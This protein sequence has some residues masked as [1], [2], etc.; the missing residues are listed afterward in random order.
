MISPFFF[1]VEL[2]SFYVHFGWGWVER[3][4]TQRKPSKTA[5]WVEKTFWPMDLQKYYSFVCVCVFFKIFVVDQSLSHSRHRILTSAAEMS[6]S[7]DSWKYHFLFAFFRSSRWTVRE[8]DSS[9]SHS[10]RC[11]TAS[12]CG[13]GHAPPTLLAF[14]RRVCASPLLRPQWYVEGLGKVF[15]PLWFCIYT[16][17][18]HGYDIVCSVF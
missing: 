3:S 14:C 16:Q 2:L 15:P 1:P 7:G 18:F 8:R 4:S 10:R 11:T 12:C 6:W 9:L 17:L 13:T 5:S